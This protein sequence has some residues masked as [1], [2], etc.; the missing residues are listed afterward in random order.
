M[1]KSVQIIMILFIYLFIFLLPNG[2]AV[3]ESYSIEILPYHLL[4]IIYYI[5]A[6]DSVSWV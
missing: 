4:N 1:I 3:T 5:V 2:A 6:N